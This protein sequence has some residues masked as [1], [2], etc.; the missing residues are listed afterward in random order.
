MILCTPNEQRDKRNLG[1]KEL[2]DNT[3]VDFLPLRIMASNGSL[4][5]TSCIPNFLVNQTRISYFLGLPHSSLIPIKSSLKQLVNHYD[6]KKIKNLSGILWLE[7]ARR[8]YRVNASL[9]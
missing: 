5:L 2:L 4:R 9:N 3:K 6:G 1:R 8:R 7:D